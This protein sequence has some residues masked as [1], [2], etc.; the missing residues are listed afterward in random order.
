MWKNWFNMS[1][2]VVLLKVTFWRNPPMDRAG[3]EADFDPV[4][5]MYGVYICF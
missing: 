4:C 5:Y 2:L 1:L 3:F